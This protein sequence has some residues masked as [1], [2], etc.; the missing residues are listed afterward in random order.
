MSGGEQKLAQTLKTTL[1]AG[2]RR[3]KARLS[4]LLRPLPGRNLPKELRAGRVGRLA[5]RLPLGLRDPGFADLLRCIDDDGMIHPDNNVTLYF[6]GTQA[7]DAMLTAISEAQREVLVEAYIFEDDD[8]GHRFLDA[9]AST[10]ARGVNVKVLADAYGSFWTR[11]EFW[12][13]MRDAGIAVKLFHP[14]LSKLWWHAFRDHRKVIVTDRRIAFTGGMNIGDEYLSS[15]RRERDELWRDTHLRLTGPASEEMAG[16]F[17]E[18]WER[19]SG[20]TLPRWSDNWQSSPPEEETRTTDAAVLVLESWPLRGHHETASALAAIVEAASESVWITNAYF[21][22]NRL[23]VR[24]LERAAQRG[25]DVRLLL[26]GQTDVPLVRHAGHGFFTRLLNSGIRVFEYQPAVLHAKTLV[27]DGH[28]A[29][30]GSSNLDL[31]SF[32]YNAECNL[33]LLDA[34]LA[35]Q[36]QHQFLADLERSQEVLLDTWRQRSW[37]HRLGDALA[38][39]LGPLL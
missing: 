13:E 29:V 10:A 33:V 35:G 24:I 14:L 6:D 4:A 20:E 30:V 15:A 12:Q 32:R 28:V 11:R 3:G 8:S 39:K 31:R 7:L 34:H 9:L 22:P 19:A 25:V 1:Q 27:A 38:R 37:M 5:R 21:A 18:S 17:A 36:L 26:P 2:A 16:V 23:A